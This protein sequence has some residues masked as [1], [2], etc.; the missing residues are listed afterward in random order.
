MFRRRIVAPLLLLTALAMPGFGAGFSFG[1]LV[2]A[3][4]TGASPSQGGVVSLGEGDTASASGATTP[5]GALAAQL[6]GL[7]AGNGSAAT[8][9]SSIVQLIRGK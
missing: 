4:F 6:Y 5:M 1:V 8:D 3:G 7:H 2:Q 9:F